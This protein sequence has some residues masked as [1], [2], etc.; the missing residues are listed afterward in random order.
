[1]PRRVALLMGGLPS[2][3]TTPSAELVILVRRLLVALL[4]A[5]IEE[6]F[7]WTSEGEPHLTHNL[8]R[9]SSILNRCGAPACPT[10]VFVRTEN[11]VTVCR[12]PPASQ[13]PRPQ[14]AESELSVRVLR[15]LATMVTLRRIVIHLAHL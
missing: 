12:I 14:I 1:M 6:L 3:G 4:K 11:D 13:S 10:T 5:V 9:S 7:C 15:P 8:V 2:I